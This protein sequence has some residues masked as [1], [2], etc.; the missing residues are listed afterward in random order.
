MNCHLTPY[1]HIFLHHPA[2]EG[3]LRNGPPYATW[4]FAFERNNKIL[5]RFNT[6]GHAGGEVEGT[7]LRS[8]V[9]SGLVQ[10]LVSF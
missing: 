3:I 7:V 9:K 2:P 1:F 4:L 10:D 5:S 8:W 6:N